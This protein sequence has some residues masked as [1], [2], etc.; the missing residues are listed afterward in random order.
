MD[1]GP[2]REPV[3][4]T[5]DFCDTCVFVG[6]GYRAYSVPWGLGYDACMR[7]LYSLQIFDMGIRY[8]KEYTGVAIIY[9]A[10]HY[11]VG[12]RYGRITV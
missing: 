11:L 3:K 4:N 6:L 12:Q 9:G 7:V 8:N 2:D 10:S 5:N 1:A